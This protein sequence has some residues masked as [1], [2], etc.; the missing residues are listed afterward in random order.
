MRR[1]S[2]APNAWWAG[3]AR[4]GTLEEVIPS[5]PSC[6]TGR[7][8]RTPGHPGVRTAV[9]RGQGQITAVCTAFNADSDG[10]QMAVPAAVGGG[11]A[12]ARIHHAR[13]EQHPQASDASRSPCPQD[14]VIGLYYLTTMKGMVLEKAGRSATSARPSWS[15]PR[16]TDLQAKSNCGLRR[17]GAAGELGAA[18]DYQPGQPY[19]LE[20][21][22]VP[23]HE[24]TPETTRSST[25]RWARS[26]CPRW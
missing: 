21:W 19:I 16:R 24:T 25:S 18:W 9:G 15:R 22:P 12:E 6:S 4:G 5:T 7:R 11:S 1:T 14:M 10:D 13:H 20:T 2:R 3:P 17:H 8:P 26:S 23:V